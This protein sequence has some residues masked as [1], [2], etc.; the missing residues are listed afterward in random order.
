MTENI[1]QLTPRPPNSIHS[2]FQAISRGQR[3]SFVQN[4]EQFSY[5]QAL[6]N[7]TPNSAALTLTDRAAV[8]I[9]ELE[10][11]RHVEEADAQQK[12]PVKLMRMSTFSTSDDT[13][14]RAQEL[15][16]RQKD[17]IKKVPLNAM[18]DRNS[19]IFKA[20][21]VLWNNMRKVQCIRK[22]KEMNDLE[23]KR[24][25]EAHHSEVKGKVKDILSNAK[26]NYTDHNNYKENEIEILMEWAI[27]I[28]KKTFLG[29]QLES[30]LDIVENM[31]MRVYKDKECLFYEGDVGNYY[32]ILFS[33][34]IAIYVGLPQASHHVVKESRY[35][36]GR[37]VMLD[38]S[39]LGTSI[40]K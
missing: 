23:N 32:Y 20:V 34:T 31:R 5:F 1:L 25:E 30:V 40:L 2:R 29:V 33:G 38:P 39:F 17:S 18:R 15:L 9:Q 8:I 27:K 35:N 12:K 19:L 11:N 14:S 6:Q 24:I 3:N 13:S 22:W 28:Q 26:R 7:S 10:N 36:A 16:P 37:A 21:V 4:A